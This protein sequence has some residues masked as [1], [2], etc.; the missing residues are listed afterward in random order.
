MFLHH[1]SRFRLSNLLVAIL[2]IRF[3]YL[4]FLYIYFWVRWS[5]DPK[6]RVLRRYILMFPAGCKVEIA[7][8]LSDQSWFSPHICLFF[9]SYLLQEA[10]CHINNWRF[11]YNNLALFVWLFNVRYLWTFSN[12]LSKISATVCRELT[13]KE[14]KRRNRYHHFCYEFCRG[15]WFEFFFCKWCGTRPRHNIVTIWTNLFLFYL[16]S[17][18]WTRWEIKKLSNDRCRRLEVLVVKASFFFALEPWRW[19]I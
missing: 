7:K 18:L 9:F 8:G 13:T 1:L 12:L 6:T 11:L 5:L 4:I 15:I 17:I 2:F 19:I 14:L 10:G 3:L 16:R